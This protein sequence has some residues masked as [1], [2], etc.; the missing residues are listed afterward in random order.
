[1]SLK[2]GGANAR[3][4]SAAC[5]VG[6]KLS[7]E[8]VRPLLEGSEEVRVDTIPPSG[9]SWT[10]NA[11]GSPVG[12]LRVGRCGPLAGGGCGAEFLSGGPGGGVG[13][14][15]SAGSHRGRHRA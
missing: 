11:E 2:E 8:Q 15:V 14:A 9:T 3:G 1:M 12:E 4:R 10:S 5:S 7:L 13:R 6:K